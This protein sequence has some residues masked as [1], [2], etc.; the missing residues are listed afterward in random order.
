MAGTT[1]TRNEV[2]IAFNLYCRTPFGQLHAHNAEIIRVASMLERTPGSL[3]MK[4]CNL[5]SLDPALRSRGIRG[6]SNISKVERALWE[7]FR[8]DP[9]TVGFE[10][11]LA[12]ANLCGSAPR[13]VDAVE[14]EDISGADRQ[15]VTKVR[16][17]Q[18]LFRS[19]VLS[20]YRDACAVCGIPISSLLMA[21]HIVGWAQDPANRMNPHNGICLCSLHDRAFDAGVLLVCEDYTVRITRLGTDVR[22]NE[23]VMQYLLRYQGKAIRLPD[24]WH[25]DP[26][27][28]RRHAKSVGHAN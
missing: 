7:Q 27:L 17:N 24:R 10:S 1:W 13:M 3:A 28:L 15:T 26:E 21:S 19:M 20:G 16:V 6:L 18:H 11:E 9:E 14:W 25:P 22:Q 8:Q 4:C 12:M 2:L 5:A 23:A